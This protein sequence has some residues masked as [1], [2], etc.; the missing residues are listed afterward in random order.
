MNRSA[1]QLTARD[2]ELVKV[3]FAHSHPWLRFEAKPPC[4][5]IAFDFHQP[6][7]PA[8]IAHFPVFHPD[9]HINV[10]IL[11][12][13][14]ACPFGANPRRWGGVSRAQTFSVAINK[15][16]DKSDFCF[17][18]AIFCI[19]RRLGSTL[20][21]SPI[22]VLHLLST[23]ISL[24]L[25]DGCPAVFSDA[26]KDTAFALTARFGD[27]NFMTD[28]FAVDLISA[29]VHGVKWVASDMKALERALRAVS[30]LCHGL[31]TTW[32][33]CPR[34]DQERVFLMV[35]LEDT[36]L[37]LHA[38]QVPLD[39]PRAIAELYRRYQI[40]WNPPADPVFP[41]LLRAISLSLAPWSRASESLRGRVACRRA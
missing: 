4:S 2:G 34:R 20:T 31:V 12:D 16:A 6:M 3:L 19:P 11:I 33:L 25:T 27:D 35:L 18:C 13:T 17:K 10:G 23:V 14:C 5:S 29:I 1:K 24:V 21:S 8:T 7:P 41:R 32:T 37:N 39:S 26:L 15:P 22:G 36:W 40:D 9:N 30:R 38:E 28:L